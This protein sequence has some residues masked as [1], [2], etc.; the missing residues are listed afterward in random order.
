MS[1]SHSELSAFNTY[2][3]KVHDLQ[4]QFCTQAEAFSK[5]VTNYQGAPSE[6]EYE[7]FKANLQHMSLDASKIHNG[8]HEISKHVNAEYQRSLPPKKRT[9]N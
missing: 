4:Q 9:I 5:H 8:V 7:K 2:V 1:F 3:N 6:Y